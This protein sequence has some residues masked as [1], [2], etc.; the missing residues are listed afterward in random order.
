LW[1]QTDSID[2]INPP[3]NGPSSLKNRC[4]SHISNSHPPPNQPGSTLTRLER[5]CQLIW[6]DQWRLRVSTTDLKIEEHCDAC[7][8]ITTDTHIIVLP[9]VV[10]RDQSERNKMKEDTA[11]GQQDLQFVNL[12][13]NLKLDVAAR[14][15]VRSHVARD[16][17]RR[18][19]VSGSS[20]LNID[21]NVAKRATREGAL[22]QKHRFRF[23]LQGLQ[24]TGK[25]STR[26]STTRKV[27]SISQDSFLPK[28]S[29]IR[30]ANVTEDPGGADS[31]NIPSLR[32]P[33]ATEESISS[34]SVDTSYNY[35]SMWDESYPTS[36]QSST[37][38]QYYI[39]SQKSPDRFGENQLGCKD[40]T[41]HNLP[42]PQK[43]HLAT[44]G[45]GN[46]DPFNTVP[47]M[48]SSCR[49][50]ILMHH[51]KHSISVTPDASPLAPND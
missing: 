10:G 14:R 43:L 27:S 18:A 49:T 38:I 16:F 12:P 13:N 41:G 2:H 34:L 25:Q 44:V 22:G 4:L 23:G 51:C 9:N 3:A 40:K 26:T 37:S 39:T 11:M 50:Q 29:V 28:S 47:I 30:C 48:D 15:R 19:K 35:S 17:R 31:L 46:L 21:L 32:S 42:L 20:S 45:T 6:A 33:V 36:S 7:S 8:S 1:L 24:E 5:N